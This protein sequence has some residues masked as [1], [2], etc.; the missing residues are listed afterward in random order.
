VTVEVP[1]LR[2]RRPDIA[3]LLVQFTSQ[4]SGRHRVKPPRF[5]RKVK[6]LLLEHEWPGNVRELRNVV[7]TLCLLRDGR[8]VRMPDLPAAIQARRTPETRVA[9]SKTLTLDLDRDLGTMIRQIVEE[10]LALER[11][12]TVRAAARLRISTRTVQRY[13]SSGRVSL[14]G[15]AAS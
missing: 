4:L 12:S 8:P 13:L 14:I 11:G 10:T 9:S 1:P 3:P 6:A 5:G 7:E 15:A 2:E